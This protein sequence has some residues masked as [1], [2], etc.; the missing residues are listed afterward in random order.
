MCTERGANLAD[1]GANLADQGANLA[2]QGANLPE[3]GANL[4]EQGAQMLERRAADWALSEQRATVRDVGAPHTHGINRGSSGTRC[5][6][7]LPDWERPVPSVRCRS[8]P[9][10][11]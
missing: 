9:P 4:P 5:N 10:H 2:D 3:Q 1:Q 6:S 11:A 7:P 8:L